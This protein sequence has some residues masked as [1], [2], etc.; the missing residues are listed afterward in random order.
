[1]NT[2]VAMADNAASNIGGSFTPPTNGVLEFLQVSG[3][4]DNVFTFIS[5]L[6]LCGFIF[7][8]INRI[9]KTVIKFYRFKF[10]ISIDVNYDELIATLDNII[11]GSI[12]DY[13]MLNGLY[14]QYIGEQQEASLRQYVSNALDEQLSDTFLKKLEFI[15]N[16]DAIPD[17]LARRILTTISIYVAKNN[18]AIKK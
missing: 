18:A 17:L 3:L 13:V 8:L 2:I 11:S 14:E 16:K 12:S 1:M 5:I 15:Y 4:I 6:I 9:V 7:L 10:I